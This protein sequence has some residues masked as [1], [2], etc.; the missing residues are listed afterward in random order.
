[1]TA[2]HF[3]IIFFYFGHLNSK[4]LLLFF[5]CGSAIMPWCL[6]FRVK[7]STWGAVFLFSLHILWVSPLC[8]AVTIHL[9]ALRLLQTTRGVLAELRVILRWFVAKLAL[10]N[11]P[12]TLRWSYVWTYVARSVKF[13]VTP[14]GKRAPEGDKLLSK[15]GGK[16]YHYKLIKKV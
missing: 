14:F 6:H 7:T 3:P 8:H 9:S 4:W 15:Q 16:L 5:C 13:Y 11:A 2:K 10:G 1:M 12:W